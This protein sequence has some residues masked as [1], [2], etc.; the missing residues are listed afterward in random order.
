MKREFFEAEASGIDAIPRYC[1]EVTVG[2]SD[3]AG[4]VEGVARSSQRL[5]EEHAELAAT[6]AALET[7]QQ[8][9]TD[10]SDEARMLSQKA[11]D[12]LFRGTDLIR[13]S[14]GQVGQL[15]VTVDTLT[16]HVTG[17][18]A[19]MEQ[20]RRT[21]QDIGRIADTTNI[22]AFNAMI[23][24]RRAGDAGKTFAVVADEVKSLANDTRKATEEISRTIDTLGSE[25]EQVVTRIA[26][27]AQASDEARNS[28]ASIEGTLGEVI[29]FVEEVDRQNALIA[30]TTG[31]I[32]VHVGEVRKIVAS[33]DAATLDNEAKLDTAHSRMEQL[34]MTANVM[35]DNIVGAGLSPA[36]S[37]MVERAQAAAREIAELTEAALDAGELAESA[38][39]DR[40]Y[41]LIP[42]SDPKC[43]ANR[44]MPWAHRSWRPVYDRIVASDPQIMAV[45]CTDMNGHL[46]AH[47]SEFSR[48]PT[49][50]K[51]HDTKHCRNGR[52]ILDAID[53]KA[54]ESRAPYM[55]AVYRQ[56]GDG[57]SYKVVRN[58]CVPLEIAGRRWG[59]LELAYSF[60]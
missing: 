48:E 42:G 5:R 3:V 30:R 27:G 40:D 34:E 33:F 60:G 29:G 26:A 43:F 15:L 32:G 12:R 23:E 56:E 19:A 4:I 52:I 9:V 51:A 8:Q 22:L 44:L 25:A 18:A 11:V 10:A 1:G 31:G 54:K 35:F 7:E 59:D 45:A 13:S 14:L 28:I 55:M 2:C 21:S 57:R 41:Q 47:L 36:D 38:L 20:V 16:Q 24:A 17:F 50:D 37:L 46:P 6:I 39:F 53:R 49:G 58:V